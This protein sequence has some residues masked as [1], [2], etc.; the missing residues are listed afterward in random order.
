M[1]P[2]FHFFNAT[3]RISFGE[4]AVKAVLKEVERTGSQRV[5]VLGSKSTEATPSY[6]AI[7]RALGHRCVGQF[8]GITAHVPQDCVLAGARAALAAR[9]DVLLAIGG[10]SVIDATKVM[11]VALK[12]GLTTRS[13]LH[14]AAV[15]AATDGSARPN[16]AADWL[17]MIAVPTT[18]SAAEFTWFA[19]CSDTTAR[20][21]E[22][23]GYPMTAP[24]AVI[25][26]PIVTLDTPM[27]LFLSSGIKA[28]DHAAEFMAMVNV[29]PCVDAF[30]TAALALLTKGL[31][32]VLADPKDLDA[33]F[34]CQR[35]MAMSIRI[36]EFG[37]RVGASHAIGHVFGAHA[38]VGH[39]YTSCVLLPAVMRYN[40][41]VNA[42]KQQMIAQAMGCA[43]ME[44]ADAI[45]Q[46]VISLN[47]PT[48]IRDVGVKRE[49]FQVIADK[50]M[51]DF[52]IKNNPRPVTQTSQVLEILESAW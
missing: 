38:G 36:L 2:S 39:G 20:V 14:D 23:F 19:G 25:V 17:R 11:L 7:I 5:F 13:E 52:G 37:A 44:A 48:R 47:L 42:P 1:T 30:G 46:L 9:A 12:L 33:R 32:R 34:D 6:Q 50:V 8:S 51:H 16:D 28:V 15:F 26:D 31:P 18:L 24:R 27:S 35:G 10:G 40:K 4:P 29:D 3:E 21:K 22:I 41:V 45:E 49:D 43:G